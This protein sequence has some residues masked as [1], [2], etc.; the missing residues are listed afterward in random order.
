MGKWTTGPR[1]TGDGEALVVDS[2]NGV[3]LRD[4]SLRGDSTTGQIGLRTTPESGPSDNVVKFVAENLGLCTFKHAIWENEAGYGQMWD[5][6]HDNGSLCDTAD[7]A[8]YSPG[9]IPQR[10]LIMLKQSHQVAF[11]DVFNHTVQHIGPINGHFVLDKGTDWNV[12]YERCMAEYQVQE[13][14]F[15]I[16]GNN[17][18]EIAARNAEGCGSMGYWLKN[19]NHF[20]LINTKSAG[21]EGDS[22]RL[23]L[24]MREGVLW[25]G[26]STLQ[27]APA[28]RSISAQRAIGTC[29]LWGTSTRQTGR[30]S[31]RLRRC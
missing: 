24:D 14:G 8:Y 11:T 4:L 30:G 25:G 9:P 27:A 29:T 31:E 23:N 18:V 16:H 21:T 17:G 5:F 22:C 20:A 28:C 19:S 13:V 10:R 7:D 3:T 26:S 15:V 6:D 12:R 1:Y 2:A